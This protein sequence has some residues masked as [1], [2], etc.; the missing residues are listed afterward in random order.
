MKVTITNVTETETA[1]TIIGVTKDTKP[2][3]IQY[4]KTLLTKALALATETPMTIIGKT[5]DFDFIELPVTETYFLPH[6]SPSI[7]AEPIT[8]DN[9]TPKK[10]S[11]LRKFFTWIT[12]YV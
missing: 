11:R 10:G 4:D 3:K 9:G 7:V 8:M 1:I 12:K 5:F 6:K 2:F